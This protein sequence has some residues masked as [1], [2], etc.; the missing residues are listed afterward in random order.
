MRALLLLFTLLGCAHRERRMEIVDWSTVARRTSYDM[1]AARAWTLPPQVTFRLEGAPAR[2]GETVKLTGL[3]ENAGPEPRTMVV[4]PVGA[5]G[6]FVQPAPGAAQRR[7]PRPGEPPRMP[8]APPPPLLF[9]LPARTA[10]RM[11]S[12]ISLDDWLWE[13]GKPR[14]LEWSYL[15]W[16][17]PKP[18]GRVAVPEAVLP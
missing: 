15:F 11:T 1:E 12:A 14:E 2:S 13:E 18:G 4:F 7:P 17:E 3:L 10:V 8:P 6:F 9:E 16:S 5:W